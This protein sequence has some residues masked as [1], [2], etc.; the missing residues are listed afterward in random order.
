MKLFDL[1]GKKAM[2]TGATRGIGH[3]MAE[4]LLEAGA[5][6]AIVG[7]SAA[8]LAVAE[9]FTETTGRRAV[10]IQADLSNREQLQRA[11]DEA[12]EKLEG[13]DILVVNHGINRR[14]VD[15]VNYRTR[16]GARHDG[17]AYLHSSYGDRTDLGQIGTLFRDRD[18]GRRH[19]NSDG[20]FSF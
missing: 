18:A 1:T 6:T 2:V 15:L 11:F 9:K 3:A 12:V 14:L 20:S 10:G 19:C 5:E 16:M 4:A 8:A 7:T 13:L 17:A